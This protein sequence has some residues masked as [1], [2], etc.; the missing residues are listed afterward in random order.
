M[1]T[2]LLLGNL[3]GTNL[4]RVYLG[5]VSTTVDYK[6]ILKYLIFGLF[7]FHPTTCFDLPRSLSGVL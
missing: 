5:S 6:P 3:K 1:H 4:G 7:Y 2:N